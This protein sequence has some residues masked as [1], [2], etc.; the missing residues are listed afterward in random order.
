LELPPRVLAELLGSG[1]EIG[2]ADSL[3]NDL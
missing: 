1:S 3:E 2:L